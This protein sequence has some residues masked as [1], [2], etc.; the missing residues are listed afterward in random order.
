MPKFRKRKLHR[1]STSASKRNKVSYLDETRNRKLENKDFNEDR[2]KADGMFETRSGRQTSR[3]STVNYD[4]QSSND[5]LSSNSDSTCDPVWEADDIKRNLRKGRGSIEVSSSEGEESAYEKSKNV[6]PRKRGPSVISMLPEKRTDIRSWNKLSE[7]SDNSDEEVKN[8]QRSIRKVVNC[9]THLHSLNFSNPQKTNSDNPKFFVSDGSS[10]EFRLNAAG[11]SNNEGN[12]SVLN[13]DAEEEKRPRVCV[14][15]RERNRRQMNSKSR[16]TRKQN[17]VKIKSRT[18]PVKKNSKRRAKFESSEESDWEEV[19]ESKDIDS[20]NPVIPHDGVDIMLALP[21]E[22][23]KKAKHR[24]S[25]A[26]LFRDY[27]RMVLRRIIK[28]NHFNLHKTNLLCL[29]GYSFHITELS[30]SPLIKALLMS[31]VPKNIQDITPKS[32]K[33]ET[34]DKILAWFHGEFCISYANDVGTS[35]SLFRSFF[36]TRKGSPC[37]LVFVFAALM[38]HLGVECRIVFSYNPVP[39]KNF[40]YVDNPF[41]LGN[42]DMLRN[43]SGTTSLENRHLVPFKGSKK[44]TTP[45]TKKKI[46]YSDVANLS[47]VPERRA[48]VIFNGSSAESDD[49]NK[50]TKSRGN[51]TDSSVRKSSRKKSVKQIVDCEDSDFEEVTFFKKSE[52]RTLKRSTNEVKHGPVD[53]WLEIYLNSAKK[54]V[55]VDCINDLIDKEDRMEENCSGAVSYVLAFTKDRKLK[56]V[57]ERYASGWLN[58]TPKIRVDWFCGPDW[59]EETL[60]PYMTKGNKVEAENKQLQEKA[61][62]LP[63]PKS[64]AE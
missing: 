48:R 23:Q 43:E 2:T 46:K 39:I 6:K 19:G 61:L 26:E 52:R 33:L 55:C 12:E 62:N 60:R 17:D 49:A 64:I 1:K 36:A 47:V 38:W 58:T 59:W 16:V 35:E 45:K 56:D 37:M 63:L 4:E 53:E 31:V 57:T 8:P 42:F 30:A 32:F 13:S 15:K 11:K 29:L 54:W 27:C 34:I 14:G 5:D 51:K 28:E 50:K 3:K 24:R 20:Y 44:V 41:R 40:K 21:K 9:V 10:P 25:N 7:S 22:L 18:S